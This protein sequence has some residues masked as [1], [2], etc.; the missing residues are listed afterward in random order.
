MRSGDRKSRNG[1]TLTKWPYLC[2]EI[3]HAACSNDATPRLWSSVSRIIP[4]NRTQNNCCGTRTLPS[5]TTPNF[6]RRLRRVAVPPVSEAGPI[7][8]TWEGE[9]SYYNG[10]ALAICVETGGARPYCPFFDD[11]ASLGLPSD[12]RLRLALTLD[13]S[14]GLSGTGSSAP[15]GVVLV[16]RPCHSAASRCHCTS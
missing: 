15:A 2:E 13:G 1:N 10:D 11:V 3:A 14:L 16:P 6:S 8:V 9:W 12:A 7:T 5:F 4:F